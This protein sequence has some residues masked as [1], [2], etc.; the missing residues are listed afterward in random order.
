MSTIPLPHA[1]IVQS[2]QSVQP[3]APGDILMIQSATTQANIPVLVLGINKLDPTQFTLDTSTDPDT[4]KINTSVVAADPP[5]TAF[6]PTLAIDG[7]GNSLVTTVMVAKKIIRGKT[8]SFILY[9]SGTVGAATGSTITVTTIGV[10]AN[11][12]RYACACAMAINTG[13]PVAC[14]AFIGS[15]GQALVSDLAGFIPAGAA[16]FTISGTYEIL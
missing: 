11:N 3:F 1:A 10:P 8:M 4:V 6:T 12:A 13:A 5:W 7:A 2:I 9:W 14:S 16:I 15:A